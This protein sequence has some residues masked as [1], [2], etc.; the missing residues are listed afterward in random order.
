MVLASVMLVGCNSRVDLGP[1]ADGKAAE[2]IRNALVASK[3]A[4]TEDSAAAAPTGTGWATLKGQFVYDGDPKPMP[5]YNVTKEHEVCAPGGTAHQ[6]ESLMVVPNTKTIKNVVVF[7]RDASRV[8]E[9]A[10]PKDNSVDFDQKACVFLS[11]V[12]GVTVGQTLT[13]KNSDPIG[14]NTNIV[15]AGFNQLIP[16][17]GVI[18]YKVQKDSQVPIQVTCSI[19]PWMTAYLLPRKNGYFAVTGEDGKFEITNVPAGEPLE[20]QVWHEIGA[21]AG[22]GLVGTSADAPELKW[23]N[24]GRVAITLQPDEVKEVKIVVPA[25]AFRM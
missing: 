2:A 4:A 5:P 6:Q 24:R 20:F 25:K 22:G 17:G 14:H 23:S 21:A 9:S 3:P 7:L 16:A 18:P 13:I 11:H 12:A 1:V 10:Q 15:G 19:H 8:H